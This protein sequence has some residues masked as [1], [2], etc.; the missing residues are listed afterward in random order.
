MFFSFKSL[1]IIAESIWDLLLNFQHQK[2]IAFYFCFFEEFCPFGLA[3]QKMQIRTKLNERANIINKQTW[4]HFPENEKM[5]NCQQQT[6]TVHIRVLQTQVVTK[7]Y[8][9]THILINTY[10]N[11]NFTRIIVKGQR[12]TFHSMQYYS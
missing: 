8:S 6:Y 3:L 4:I 11:Q 2:L 9:V 5:R 1:Q 7:E 10:M 12:Q